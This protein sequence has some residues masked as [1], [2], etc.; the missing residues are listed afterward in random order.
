M[1][2][3][4]SQE[5]CFHGLEGPKNRSQ[6]RT[7]LVLWTNAVPVRGRSSEIAESWPPV[8]CVGISMCMIRQY[9]IWQASSE[10]SA[11]EELLNTW[12]PY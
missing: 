4:D 9:T 2:L 1:L 12:R 8:V 3:C 11:Q 7:L 5:T 10:V 6:A